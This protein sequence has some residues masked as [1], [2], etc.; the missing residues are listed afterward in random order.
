M[1]AQGHAD[2][3]DAILNP[4]PS[5]A[6]KLLADLGLASLPSRDKVHTEIEKNLLLPKSSLPDHWL[7]TYQL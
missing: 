3:V 1:P 5:N 7:P 6:D 2:I 4:V